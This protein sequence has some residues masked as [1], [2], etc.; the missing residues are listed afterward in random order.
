MKWEEKNRTDG[1]GVY[2]EATTP[3]GRNKRWRG[4]LRDGHSK[5]H[6]R[7]AMER[8]V[9]SIETSINA[10]SLTIGPSYALKKAKD[11][12]RLCERVVSDCKL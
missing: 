1:K 6:F 10:P 2:Y 3:N 5:R 7:T 4:K 9:F 12:M 8:S 11:A